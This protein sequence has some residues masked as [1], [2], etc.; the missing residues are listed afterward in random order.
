MFHVIDLCSEIRSTSSNR[1]SSNAG[2]LGH[3]CI[4]MNCG[5]FQNGQGGW[6]EPY[7]TYWSMLSIFTCVKMWVK[8]MFNVTAGRSGCCMLAQLALLY[9]W[10]CGAVQQLY[11]LCYK[12]FSIFLSFMA[13]IPSRTMESPVGCLS[14]TVNSLILSWQICHPE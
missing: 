7:W 8:V 11:V 4:F 13:N 5:I 1:W 9:I 3:I 6:V 12:Y 14:V 2:R 10:L